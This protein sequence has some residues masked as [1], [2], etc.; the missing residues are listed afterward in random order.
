[1]N[2]EDSSKTE[3]IDIEG[4]VSLE[5]SSR[6]LDDEADAFTGHLALPQHSRTGEHIRPIRTE[7][8]AVNSIRVSDQNFGVDLVVANHMIQH[9]IHIVQVMANHR[10]LCEMWTTLDDMV[11]RGI[12]QS[13]K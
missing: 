5:E 4:E 6:M 12:N 1:M 2:E 9:M 11:Q 13:L 7:V 10:W 8:E 3:L